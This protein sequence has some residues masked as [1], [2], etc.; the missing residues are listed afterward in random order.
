M[1]MRGQGLGPGFTRVATRRS[2]IFSLDGLELVLTPLEKA[3]VRSSVNTK[4][5]SAIAEVFSTSRRSNVFPSVFSMARCP[6]E[7]VEFFEF[8]LSAWLPTRIISDNICPKQDFPF[9][10]LL[11]F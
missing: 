8:V 10:K 9:D 4:P 7:S 1:R 6:L 3:S 2:V 11:V 5:P